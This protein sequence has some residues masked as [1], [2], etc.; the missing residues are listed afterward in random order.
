MGG[1]GTSDRLSEN[2]DDDKQEPSEL[3]AAGASDE[4]VT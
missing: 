4:P 1:G 3:P 2:I